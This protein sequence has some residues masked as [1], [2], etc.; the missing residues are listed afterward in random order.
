VSAR[1]ARGAR[2]PDRPPG[3]RLRPE[4]IVAPVLAAVTVLGAWAAV[5]HSSGDGW[6]QTLGA[7]IGGF[8][9]V[10]LL[11]PALYMRRARCRVVDNPLDGSAGTGVIIEVEVNR[12]LRLR[13]ID[14][15]GPEAV[16]NG[17]GPVRLG[18]VA[19]HRGVLAYTTVELASAA[20]FGLLWWTR[21]RR[22]PL[23]RPLTIAPRHGVPHARP[24]EEG[25]PGADEELLPVQRRSGEPRGVRPYVA[26]DAPS[27]VHW[28]ATAHRGSL[29]VR[30]ME[31]AAEGSVT[32]TVSLPADPTAAEREA[33]RILATVERL[34]R[35]GCAVTLITTEADGIVSGRVC[36]SLEAGRRLARAQPGPAPG[37]LR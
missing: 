7:L 20:P 10:G 37:S 8:L 13:P 6:V 3:G 32:L 18:I 33:E 19:D 25:D 30:E 31:S 9:L 4:K 5:A 16:A 35:G 28:P 27:S 26:G 29:M 1:E 14:P 12:P 36:T 2:R 11:G 21:R 17:R 34:V 23:A 15:P 22:L 24:A